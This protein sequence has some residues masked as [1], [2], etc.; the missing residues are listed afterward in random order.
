MNRYSAKTGVKAEVVCANN[1]VRL[2]LIVRG[3]NLTI[4][5]PKNLFRNLRISKNIGTSDKMLIQIIC[6]GKVIWS[7]NN[8]VKSLI[9]PGLVPENN[10]KILNKF[11]QTIHQVNYQEEVLNDLAED[12]DDDQPIEHEFVTDPSSQSKPFG[13][14]LRYS[15]IDQ[16][17]P[18]FQPGPSLFDAIEVDS[19]TL[20]KDNILD[21]DDT[22]DVAVSLWQITPQKSSSVV[23]A[24]KSEPSKMIARNR[25]KF[26]DVT[27]PVSRKYTNIKGSGDARRNFMKALNYCRR[28][29]PDNPL[30]SKI[31]YT[32][33]NK[34]KIMSTYEGLKSS[35]ALSSISSMIPLAY[36]DKS[37]SSKP[38]DSKGEKYFSIV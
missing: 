31:S 16:L 32:S 9:I 15:F 7:C 35:G 21:G 6:K 33:A 23:K 4:N 10:H 11:R 28:F 37:L 19:P 8:P 3:R 24:S 13:S 18:S 17:P 26:P 20:S 14:A 12:R 25:L 38:D 2:K 29:Y 5:D 1:V 22:I 27:P 36:S 30:Y 34:T